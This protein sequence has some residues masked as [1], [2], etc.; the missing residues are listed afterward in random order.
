MSH[1]FPPRFCDRVEGGVPVAAEVAQVMVDGD[2]SL[3]KDATGIVVFAHGSGSS[4]K[5]PRNRQVSHALVDSGLGT[6]LFD[7]LTADEERVDMNRMGSALTKQWLLR[8]LA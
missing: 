8:H 5:S 6:L 2:L 7:L 4:R 3:P 1:R